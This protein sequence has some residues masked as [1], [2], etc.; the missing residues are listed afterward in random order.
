MLVSVFM[1]YCFPWKCYFAANRLRTASAVLNTRDFRSDS[2]DS[3][4]L[5][6][7]S[8]TKATI[9]DLRRV[10]GVDKLGGLFLLEVN[11]RLCNLLLPLCLLL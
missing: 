11:Y 5:E 3:E 6:E 9:I 10:P 1:S 4:V 8:K 2:V 7:L